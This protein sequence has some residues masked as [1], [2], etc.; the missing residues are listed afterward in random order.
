MR[1]VVVFEVKLIGV[2]NDGRRPRQP[3]GECAA[4]RGGQQPARR[5]GQA[6]DEEPARR[7]SGLAGA[8]LPAASAD[9][10]RIIIYF[11]FLIDH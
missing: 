4:P 7:R 2:D 3:V 1:P 6:V 11:I 9:R 8:R 10:A 5:T